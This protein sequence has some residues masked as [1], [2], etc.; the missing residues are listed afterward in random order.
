MS[1]R[2]PNPRLAKVH[3][4]Y[5]VDELSRLFRKHP[6]TIRN[7]IKDG[8]NPVDRARSIL[9]RGR[10][11]RGYLEGKRASGKSKCPPGTIYCFTCKAPKPPAAGMVDFTPGPGGGGI[12]T[13][14]CPNCQTVLKQIV[15]ETRLRAFRLNG[16]LTIRA[17]LRRL[18]GLELPGDDCD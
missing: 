1:R 10:D 3:W 12:I 4:I 18:P 5:T 8:L 9:I 17:V 7:W 2:Y 15:S 16:D 11:I 6:N 14:L 13:A